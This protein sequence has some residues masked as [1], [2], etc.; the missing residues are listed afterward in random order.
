M[1]PIPPK[2]REEMADDQK[3]ETI[4]IVRKFIGTTDP[5]PIYEISFLKNIKSGEKLELDPL[6]SYIFRWKK[7]KK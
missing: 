3:K 6:E 5:T 1:R 2:L 7:L 4:A